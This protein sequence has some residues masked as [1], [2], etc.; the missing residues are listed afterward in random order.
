M[1]FAHQNF[2]NACN[3][4]YLLKSAGNGLVAIPDANPFILFWNLLSI[5]S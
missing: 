1:L 5:E 3:F 2:P 4:F